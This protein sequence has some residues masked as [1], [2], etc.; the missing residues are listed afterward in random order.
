MLLR[1]LGGRWVT[2]W[3]LRWL[4]REKLRSQRSH[5]RGFAAD[6]WNDYRQHI[7][8]QLTMAAASQEAIAGLAVSALTYHKV[9]GRLRIR[10]RIRIDSA[11]GNFFR[12][13][14]HLRRRALPA[15]ERHRDT[16]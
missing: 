2:R 6:S 11:T 15:A 12:R 3:R 16:L 9:V 13:A 10:I 8:G 14:E 5:L 4:G 1:W 7:A